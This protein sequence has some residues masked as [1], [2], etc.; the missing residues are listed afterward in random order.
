MVRNEISS[1]KESFQG[2]LFIFAPS[3]SFVLLYILSLEETTK[4]K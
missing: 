1:E 3:Q 2:I 4:E